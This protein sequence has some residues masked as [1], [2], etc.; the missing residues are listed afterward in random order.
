MVNFNEEQKIIIDLAEET[1]I[2]TEVNDIN[3][4]PSYKIAEEERR[5]NEKQ[6][7]A[8][9]N[10]REKFYNEFQDKVNRGDF[11]ADNGVY[12]GSEPPTDEDVTVWIDPNGTPEVEAK[13]IFF[14]DNENLQTKYENGELKGEKGDKGEDGTIT[15]E[16]LTEE[17]KASLK[18][19]KGD[20]GDTGEAGTNGKDGADGYT[21]IKGT[22]YFTPE[23]IASLNIPTKTSQLTND[24]GF[25]TSEKQVYSTDE[26]VIGTWVDGKPIYRKCYIHQFN[27]TYDD[28][29]A[30]GQMISFIKNAVG[31]SVDSIVRLEARATN[32]KFDRIGYLGNSFTTQ[33]GS[34]DYRTYAGNSGGDMLQIGIIK[35]NPL[36]TEAIN[37]DDSTIKI[38]FEYTKT[39]D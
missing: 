16:T 28:T 15:F 6:R 31:S 2:T 7:I 14:A 24:S 23:D 19:D 12:V 1:P 20:K 38:I 37:P 4:I 34:I 9:E 3:H 32:P 27:G 36:Y 33:F 17:Q 26:Q 21:P 22:D 13:N 8:N 39:T 35:Q 10:E 18:G 5:A 29:E 11:D 25:L 30:S